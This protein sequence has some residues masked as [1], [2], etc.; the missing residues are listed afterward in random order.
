MKIDYAQYRFKH[1]RTCDGCLM[2]VNKLYT[3]R[4]VYTDTGFFYFI[5]SACTLIITMH[6]H[7]IQPD[8][9]RGCILE[10]TEGMKP[11]DFLFKDIDRSK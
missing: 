2:T 10:V 4:N 9:Y 3:Y 8:F 11:Q 7:K 1:D 6:G 5:C